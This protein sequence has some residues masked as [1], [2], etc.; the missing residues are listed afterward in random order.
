MNKLDVKAFGLA[1]GIVWGGG[2]MLLGLA[3]SFSG[4]GNEIVQFLGVY[5]LGYQAT[6]IGSLIGCL[7]GFVDMGICGLLIAWLYNKFA[8]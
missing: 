2:V 7:W 8:R 6:V 5:Y 3:A 4:N 1:T